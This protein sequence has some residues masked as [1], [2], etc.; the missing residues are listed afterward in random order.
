MYRTI[1]VLISILLLVLSVSSNNLPTIRQTAN[2][3]VEGIEK[4]S[5]LGQK[6]YSFRGIPYAEAPITG[7]DPYTGEQVDRRFKAPVALKRRWIDALK[8]HDFDKICAQNEIKQGIP[9][10]LSKM[11]EDCLFLNVNVPGMNKFNQGSILY[12]QI[13]LFT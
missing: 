12:I 7:T 10:D 1:L 2:G 3:P 6:Y 4:L 8:V 5:S 11:G 9:V 13:L